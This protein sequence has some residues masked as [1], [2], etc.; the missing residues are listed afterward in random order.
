MT[1][2][3]VETRSYFV[4]KTKQLVCKYDLSTNCLQ[5]KPLIA[6]HQVV[7]ME[8]K[9]VSRFSFGHACKEFV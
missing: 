8:T 5:Q 7:K 1:N 9:A 2:Y 3:T 4:T 6:F